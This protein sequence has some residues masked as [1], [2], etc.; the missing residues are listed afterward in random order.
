MDQIIPLFPLQLVV[1]PSSRYPLH[2]FESR[3]KTLINYCVDNKKGFGIIPKIDNDIAKIGCYVE[4][5]TILKKYDNG[6]FDIVV[7]GKN[8]FSI[9]QVDVHPDGYFTASVDEYSD[10]VT[11][12]DPALLNDIKKKFEEL[13]NKI[14]LQLDEAFWNNFIKSE[15]KSYKIAEKAGLSIAE[16]QKLLAMQNENDRLT[17]L[18]D[19]FATLDEQLEKNLSDK[20]IVLNDGFIN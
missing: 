6:E 3:Y 15:T 8:R 19:H 7:E 1:F 4:V 16:Q 5:N 11:D 2:I 12:V 14:N 10:F 20:I 17:F 13:L 9:T 18:R